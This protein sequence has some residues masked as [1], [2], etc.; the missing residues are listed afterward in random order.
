MLKGIS[1]GITIALLFTS[2][3]AAESFTAEGV[4]NAIKA[5]QKKINITHGPIAGLMSGMTM[6][7]AV[8]D[9]ALLEDVKA[10]NK[11]R[12]TLTKDNR[13]NLII[14]DLEPAYLASTKK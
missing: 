6:D 1:L 5:E 4:I 2:A 7:F 8:L 12:F 10:G 14:T 9:P 11:I 3:Y 13:G